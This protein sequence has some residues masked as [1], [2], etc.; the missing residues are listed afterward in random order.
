MAH[1]L[2]IENWRRARINL[3]FGERIRRVLEGIRSKREK[4]LHLR[5][6]FNP[7][8]NPSARFAAPRFCGKGYLYCIKRGN[9]QDL[10]EKPFTTVNPINGTRQP[11]D[12]AGSRLSAASKFRDESLEPRRSERFFFDPVQNIRKKFEALGVAVYCTNHFQCSLPQPAPKEGFQDKHSKKR[13][14]LE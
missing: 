8:A 3:K 14:V 7:T 6:N 11:P 4:S 12:C 2:T 13:P 9:I 10:C 5:H 1:F